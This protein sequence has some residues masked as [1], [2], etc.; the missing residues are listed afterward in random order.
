[1]SKTQLTNNYLKH[2]SQNPVQHFLIENFYQTMLNLAQPLDVS[3][4]L[5]VGCGEGF[6]LAKFAE[7]KIGNTFEGI[8]YSKDALSIG[9]K[10]F[11]NLTLQHASIYDLP[12][13]S[14]SFDLV[15]CTEV[16]EHLKNPHQALKEVLRVSKQYILLSVPNEPFFMLANFLRG[17]NVRS[18][19][20]DPEHINHWTIFSFQRFIKKQNAEIKTIRLPFPWIIF[21]LTV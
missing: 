11:P 3:S 4:L 14:S 18:F 5:D 10:T 16:L 17:K 6:T 12:Y 19:G 9:K 21:L 7:K 13:Q 20:N 8:D 15:I 2:M 1:M